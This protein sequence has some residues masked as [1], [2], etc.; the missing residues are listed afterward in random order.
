VKDVQEVASHSLP[1]FRHLLLV[2]GT[3]ERKN[4]LVAVLV[5]D[6]ADQLLRH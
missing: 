5:N 2:N 3:M 6:E 1:V 4:E